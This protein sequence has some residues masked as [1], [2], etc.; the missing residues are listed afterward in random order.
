MFPSSLASP[1]SNYRNYRRDRTLNFSFTFTCR[2]VISLHS[3]SIFTRRTL[4][5]NLTNRNTVSILSRIARRGH[6]HFS[7]LYQAHTVRNTTGLGVRARLSVG[8]VPGTI[9]HPRLYVHD[10]LRTTG[11]RSFPVGQLVFRALRDRRMSGC[12]RLAG[13][14]HRC[15]RFNFVA[16]VSSFNTNCSK[17]GLLTSFRPSLVGLSVTLVHS[18]S[19]SHIH[20]TVIQKVI[21]VY[22]RLGIAIVTRNVRATNRQSFLTSY[23]VFLVR[24]C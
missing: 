24:N 1:G 13:V 14:L 3:R 2:P 21:A 17:L 5:H 7:R 12:H 11:G 20:R 8:F 23:K 15:H 6:C 4:I 9:C 18:I 19:H 22:T 10:A 16:T